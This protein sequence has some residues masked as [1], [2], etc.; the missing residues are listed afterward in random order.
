MQPNISFKFFQ[1][2]S[3]SA[4]HTHNVSEFVWSKLL[5]ATEFTKT[6]KNSQTIE[7]GTLKKGKDKHM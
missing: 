1:Y 7:G 4:N 2:E 3:Y 5:G 6:K